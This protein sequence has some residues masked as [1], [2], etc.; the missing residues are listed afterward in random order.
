MH[1]NNDFK[2]PLEFARLMQSVP[3][4]NNA[5]KALIDLRFYLEK[6]Q[7]SKGFKAKIVG[8]DVSSDE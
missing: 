3:A 4:V 8:F 1:L 6:N 7:A 2:E 5:V